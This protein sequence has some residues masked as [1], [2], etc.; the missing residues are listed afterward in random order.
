MIALLLY[1]LIEMRLRQVNIK[2]S[3]QRLLENF[4]GLALIESIFN[5]GTKA[6]R[7]AQE[8]RFQ[9][10]VLFIFGYPSPQTYFGEK[11]PI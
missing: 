8:T 2:V 4:A 1:C 11:V 3:G 7:I 6:F 10:Q 5:D 9:R